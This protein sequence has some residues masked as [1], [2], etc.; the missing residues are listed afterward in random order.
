M[1][2]CIFCKIAQEEIPAHV[3]YTD[4]NIVAF[5]DSSPRAPGHTMVISRHHAATLFE[6]PDRE[7]A[8]LFVGAKKVAGIIKEVLK[9]DGF[10]MGI[11]HGAVSGQTVQHLHFHILPRWHNDGGKAIHSVI[12]NPPTE[13]LD[14]IALKIKGYIP[15][16][17]QDPEQNLF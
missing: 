2:S 5:L 7:V 15:P 14:Q 16:P 1:D 8:S 4:E 3:V 6:L 13:S 9:P 17:H 11:N 10:T 12:D